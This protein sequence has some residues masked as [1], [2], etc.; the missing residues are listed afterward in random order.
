[1]D[2]ATYSQRLVSLTDWAHTLGL[3][4]VGWQAVP[5]EAPEVLIDR[6]GRW[7][8]PHCHAGQEQLIM[9]ENGDVTLV[10]D[11]EVVTVVVDEGQPMESEDALWLATADLP[12]ETDTVATRCPSC[13]GYVTP[14][15]PV[16]WS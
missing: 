16:Q 11:A 9:L 4:L 2:A 3:E 8:C 7:T 5:L 1:M 15:N 6:S 10:A 13:S 12:K 14:A